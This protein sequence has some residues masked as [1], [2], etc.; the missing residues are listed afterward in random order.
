MSF[1]ERLL[2]DHSCERSGP[3]QPP[4]LV[5]HQRMAE[6]IARPF[7]TRALKKI[8]LRAGIHAFCNDPVIQASADIDQG[9]DKGHFAGI[10]GDVLDKRIG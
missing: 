4:E 9:S 6:K 10:G 7:P 3:E 2:L 8:H 1:S 5:G